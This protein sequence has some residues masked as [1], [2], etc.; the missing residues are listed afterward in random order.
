MLMISWLPS[1]LDECCFGQW[2]AELVRRNGSGGWAPYA[3][4]VNG[5]GDWGITRIRLPSTK[6][7]RLVPA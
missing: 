3:N 4:V 6:T 1:T 7:G 2:G 5:F